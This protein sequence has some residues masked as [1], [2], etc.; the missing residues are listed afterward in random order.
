VSSLTPEQIAVLNEY[1]EADAWANFYHCATP[2]VASTLGV[3]A[4]RVG[5]LWVTSVAKLDWTFF[6]RINGLGV[7]EPATESALDECIALLERAGC[8]NYMAQISPVAQPPELPGWLESRG[9]VRSR[10]WGKF[11][12]GNE[13]APVAPTDLTVK[14]IGEE[15]AGAFS[16]VVLTAFEMP[17]ELGP[18]VGA[19]V[20]APG[21]NAYVA[22]DGEQAVSAAALYVAG[23]I[24]WLGFGSTLESHRKRGGQGALFARRI[25]DGLKL[26]CKWFVA[27]AA[28][29]TPEAP[30]PSYH[31]MLR[32]GFQLA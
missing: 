31:N 2:E 7:R 30:N 20:G 25:E 32:A 27:E 19:I 15:H 22:F 29:D 10:N 12:R 6:N 21:W 13:P 16:D 9:F 23:D 3:S 18:M 8:K 11:Y 1:S 4:E 28:E 14:L 24:G 5:N 17:A 26:G